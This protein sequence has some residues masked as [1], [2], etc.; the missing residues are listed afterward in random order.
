MFATG[1]RAPSRATELSNRGLSFNEQGVFVGGIP[2]LTRIPA[3]SARYCWAVRPLNEINEDLTT[4]YRLPVDAG[5]KAGV[6]A[7]I[8]KA[9]DHGDLMLG[10]VAAAQIGFPDPPPIGKAAEKSDEIARCAE[11]LFRSG[12]LK[13]WDPARHPRAGVPPNP[14][15]FAPVAGESDSAEVI[16]AAM[17]GNPET[18]WDLWGSKPFIVEG[19]GGGGVPRGQLELPFPS[20]LPRLR[21]PWQSPEPRGRASKPPA[22]SEAQPRLPFWQESE[23]QLASYNKPGQPTSGI[24]KGGGYTIELRSGVDGPAASIPRGSSG[25]DGYTKTHVEGHAA[26]LMRQ[27]GITEGTLSINNPKIC[28]S[29]MDSLPKMLPPGATLSVVL[30]DNTVL[31]F[32]GIGP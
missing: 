19:G 12:L 2:L 4:V 18:P 22:P 11:R 6:L 16:P 1:L 10:A 23:P 20:G 5:S 21:W 30:P 17:V 26:A 8:A 29:C 3:G 27:Q 28:D 7:L 32:T 31:Q 13:F 25:F 9:R 24:F 14:G 15:W